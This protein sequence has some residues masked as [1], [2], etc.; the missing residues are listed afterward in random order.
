MLSCSPQDMNGWLFRTIFRLPEDEF[1]GFE[2]A[3][4]GASSS[5]AAQRRAARRPV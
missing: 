2:P 3:N 5:L 4:Y 1:Y